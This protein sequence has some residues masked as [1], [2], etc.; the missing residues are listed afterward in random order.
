MTLT[1]TDSV[2][3]ILAEKGYDPVYGA[4]PLKR[5]VQKYLQD[6]LSMK[7]L[8]ETFQDGDNILVDSTAS[9]KNFIF[10]KAS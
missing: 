7:I 10:M 5:V 2:K 6:P 1:L 4:R 9:D 8:N 3:E